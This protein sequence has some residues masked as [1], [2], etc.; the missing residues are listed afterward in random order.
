MSA[1]FFDVFNGAVL[2]VQ[3]SFG[4]MLNDV[5]TDVKETFDCT[6]LAVEH[7]L[8]FSND[9]TRRYH[10]KCGSV[11]NQTNSVSE[12]RKDIATEPR[13][14][15]TF[16]L[17]NNSE[18]LQKIPDAIDAKIN[19][20]LSEV[21]VNYKSHDNEII[22][23]VVAKESEQLAG[24]SISVTKEFHK[25]S[26]E[27]T[28]NLKEFDRHRDSPV[29]TILKE[30]KVLE[31]RDENTKIS[32]AS[33]FHQVIDQVLGKLHSIEATEVNENTKLRLILE[34]LESNCNNSF[35]DLRKQLKAWKKEESKHLSQMK[36]EIEEHEKMFDNARSFNRQGFENPTTVRSSE[37]TAL[38]TNQFTTLHNNLT[39]NNTNESLTNSTVKIINSAPVNK[40]IPPV[41]LPTNLNK[42][43]ALALATIEPTVFSTNKMNLNETVTS[44]N[45]LQPLEIGAVKGAILPV[46]SNTEPGNK[47]SSVSALNNDTVIIR[48]TAGI[49]MTSTSKSNNNTNDTMSAANT[50]VE[51]T[52]VNKS[53]SENV[54]SSTSVT[55]E[56]AAT[57]ATFHVIASNDTIPT[58]TLSY[59]NIS[60]PV[61]RTTVHI[62]TSTATVHEKSST[63][64]IISKN[65]S[66]NIMLQ[67]SSNLESATISET[68]HHR[69]I[70]LASGKDQSITE[71][72]D[73]IIS[74]NSL[75]N[76]NNAPAS[77][78]VKPE[79]KERTSDNEKYSKVT[80]KTVDD[81]DTNNTVITSASLPI[82]EK[83]SVSDNV[84]PKETTTIS[85]NK[86]FSKDNNETNIISTSLPIIE[87]TLI[88][89][90]IQLDK[91]S[92]LHSERRNKEFS[93]EITSQLKTTSE[94]VN[95]NGTNTT[96]TSTSS[97]LLST[98]ENET[99]Q[100]ID[101][102]TV[103]T[104][105]E[106]LGS[107]ANS[108]TGTL[109]AAGDDDD[110][111]VA[112][113]TMTPEAISESI[114]EQNVTAAENYETLAP[115]TN[116]PIASPA[117]FIDTVS[118]S[119]VVTGTPF[120]SVQITTVSEVIEPV[121][122]TV[123]IGNIKPLVLSTTPVTISHEVTNENNDI[124]DTVTTKTKEADGAVGTDINQTDEIS[125]ASEAQVE[126]S[127]TSTTTKSAIT[128]TTNTVFPRTE[129]MPT[130]EEDF[131]NSSKLEANTSRTPE[132]INS[133]DLN[134]RSLPLTITET[135]PV[136]RESN[137]PKQQNHN[138]NEAERN[139]NEFNA[140]TSL[141][142]PLLQ[143]G[144]PLINPEI[145]IYGQ[146][147]PPT[148]RTLLNGA[149]KLLSPDRQ[150]PNAPN[151]KPK[152]I[153]IITNIPSP[154][155]MTSTP[156][157]PIES[158][159]NNYDYPS[160]VPTPKYPMGPPYSF[161]NRALASTYRPH[162]LTTTE[163]PKTTASR[164]NNYKSTPMDYD[165]FSHRPS[166]KTEAH[167]RALKE[168]RQ[169]MANS[170]RA[171]RII[172]N[173]M[174]NRN[175][176]NAR[177]IFG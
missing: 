63:A 126:L 107:T 43:E 98:S 9:A 131:K 12:I 26:H 85:G 50:M 124:I 160:D 164:T 125:T 110:S 81:N 136:N 95:E 142:D 173:I 78:S 28:T 139:I 38:P 17:P 10:E 162:R 36:S 102:T 161:E 101:I 165:S 25:L 120:P 94:V 24:V 31:K 138:K 156:M 1:S 20:T 115:T 109:N 62:E 76:V 147:V 104:C 108:P 73:A 30:I 53:K 16:N 169:L 117:M 69:E 122:G 52:S 166:K 145:S 14:E 99:V 92:L 87:S 172:N 106:S 56:G 67:S 21:L 59:I 170:K 140:P 97:P 116:A 151:Q 51:N 77:V 22:E 71:L 18:Y 119:D 11:T 42:Q 163:R 66:N 148:I 40:T 127:S 114:P 143:T 171:E 34:D 123:P 27:V 177:N 112:V 2:S 144:E 118:S 32:E 141:S 129:N 113:V 159:K 90:A 91:I 96:I 58:N 149:S 84:E 155:L 74:N 13:L 103:S 128:M 64:E 137:T 86:E 46:K 79:E 4:K 45:P 49:E 111:R 83:T 35:V 152:D 75:L 93:T 121:E 176:F 100:A 33:E 167:Q 57:L 88:N 3:N 82:V 19:E 68:V 23:N 157:K 7:V 158:Q 175:K 130:S 48:E 150:I 8:S 41:N 65:D 61:N 105:D 39:N 6:I 174:K 132:I 70:T 47:V 146:G 72:Y 135:V 153:E 5:V 168:A 44:S 134:L 133:P 154:P 54:K 15:L 60:T 37:L 80:M 89:K 55:S 29:D